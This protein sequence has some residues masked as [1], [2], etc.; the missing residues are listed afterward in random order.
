MPSRLPRY[1]YVSSNL[2]EALN[3]HTKA[4]QA[5]PILQLLSDLWDRFSDRLSSRYACKCLL[6][7]P[8]GPLCDLFDEWYIG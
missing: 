8:T 5:A 2:V 6:G 1:G 7:K 4:V 3:S